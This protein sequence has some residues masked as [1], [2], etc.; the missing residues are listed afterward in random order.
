M[1]AAI[2]LAYLDR[3]GLGRRKR[4]VW[5]GIAAATV[6]AAALG[7]L[8]YHFVRSYDGS[9][10]QAALEG[11]TYIFAAG[12]LTYM[13]FW[14]KRESRSIKDKLSARVDVAVET[15][16]AWTLVGLVFSTVLREGIETV[17]FVLAI[18][19]ASSPSSVLLGAA[20]GLLAA[21]VVSHLIYRMGVRLNL[22]LF[23]NVVGSFLMLSAGGLL[24]DGIE[25]FQALGWIRLG[26][27][28]MWHSGRILPESS[29]LGDILHSFLGYAQAPTALQVGL[30]VVYLTIVLAF[31]WRQQ[32]QRPPKRT[33]PSGTPETHTA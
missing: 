14:M 10:T 24:S 20:A 23:F 33:H 31:L 4:E 5:A 17:V 26:V 12:V 27:H 19:L 16:S 3:V 21:L 29:F 32:A 28:V 22:A 7:A 2:V 8:I 25:D 11:V 13:T 6:L 15:G 18:A 9:P 30:Y 1:I